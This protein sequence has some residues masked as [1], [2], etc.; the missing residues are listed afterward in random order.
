MI[1]LV[2]LHGRLTAAPELRHTQNDTPVCSFA[3]AVSTGT[4]EKQR[5]HFIDCVAWKQ[6]A[7]FLCTYF[8]KGQE[9]AVSGE[10]QTRSYEDKQG[11]KRKAV[12][13]VVR[14][15]DFCGPKHTEDTMPPG[16]F[17]KGN[18]RPPQS[19]SLSGEPEECGD[20]DLPF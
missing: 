18:D 11:N 15:I 19:G 20:D 6:A 12:E 13:V 3:V 16:W 4:G 17:G 7:E 14:N 2:V 5:T 1:N 8:T 10:L 9:L